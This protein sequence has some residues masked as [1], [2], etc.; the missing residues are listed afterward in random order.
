MIGYDSI[1][2]LIGRFSS[3]LRYD[4]VKGIPELKARDPQSA[5]RYVAG[6]TKYFIANPFK[7]LREVG[8]IAHTQIDKQLPDLR[9]A[10]I[11]VGVVQSHSDSGFPDERIYKQ[12][13]LREAA[14]GPPYQD[15]QMSVDSYASVGASDAGHDDIIIHPERTTRAALE[16]LGNFEKL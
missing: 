1:P 11:R 3:K 12:T 9:E 13:V 4:L 10:G 7:A 2:R 6:P 5:K 8:A 16:M 15:L 14:Q